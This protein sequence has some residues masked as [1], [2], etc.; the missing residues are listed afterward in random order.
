[1]ISE[2]ATTKA[3]RGNAARVL[4]RA[5]QAEAIADDHDELDRFMRIAETSFLSGI[6]RAT[7]YEMMAEGRF[8]KNVRLSPRIVAWS[9]R[10]VLAWMSAR[11]AERDRAA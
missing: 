1:M 7:I 3:Q 11:V 4:H 2:P 9:R 10:E 6:P 8:P 5:R